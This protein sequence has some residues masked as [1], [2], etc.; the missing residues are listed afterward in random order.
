MERKTQ[1]HVKG[2]EDPLDGRIKFDDPQSGHKIFGTKQRVKLDFDNDR[3][4]LGFTGFE[5]PLVGYVRLEKG[6][7]DKF[8]GQLSG[9]EEGVAAF[10]DDGSEIKLS[11]R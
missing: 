5:D 1:L 6:M 2:F 3:L 8:R 4:A 10:N 7:H 11:P 9:W